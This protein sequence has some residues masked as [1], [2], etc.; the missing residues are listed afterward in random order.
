MVRTEHSH[1]HWFGTTIT[2]DLEWFKL[3]I[4]ERKLALFGNR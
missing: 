3:E 4:C 1:V 2:A